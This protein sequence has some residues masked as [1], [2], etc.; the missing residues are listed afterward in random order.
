MHW[1]VEKLEDRIRMLEPYRYR[2]AIPLACGWQEDA[3]GEVGAYPPDLSR[4]A[5]AERGARWTGRDRYIWLKAQAEVPAHWQSRRAIGVFDFG[6][7][8]GGGNSGFESLLFIDGQPYQGVDT[9]HREVMLPDDAAGRTLPLV[10]RLWSGLGGYDSG[11]VLEHTLRRADLCWLDEA[12]DDL[13]YTGRAMLD[14]VKLL[15]DGRAERHEL[16]AALDEAFLLLDWSR[17]G[18][19][20]FYAS[21][22]RAQQVLQER[23]TCLPKQH[24]VTVQCIGHTHIDVA[25]LWRLKHT[26]E[27]AARSFSTVLRLMEQYPD[28]VFLQTQPQ[29][30][31]YIKTD[32]PQ[33]YEAIRERVAE[34]RWE[35]G[36]AMWLEADCNLTSGESLVRQLLYGIRFFQQEFGVTCRYLWLPDVFGYSWALPQILRQ[37]GIRAFMTT[38]ISWNQYNRM[39]HDTFRWR[40]IDG[41]EI[42]THFI[43]TPDPG[44]AEGSFFYTYNG[45]VTAE[46]VQGIWDGY[47]DKSVNRKLLL[48]YGYGD[49]GGGVNRDMLEMRRRLSQLPGLPQVTTGRADAFFE[50]LQETVDQT[51]Q[52][53]HTW[54]GELYLELHRGTYTS[55]AYNKRM[56]RKLELLYKET[57]WLA[58]RQAL[59]AGWRSY[60]QAAL[61]AGWKIIL[62]NQFHDIIPGSSI[63]EVYEDSREEYAEAELIAR[64]VWEQADGAL[65]R[66]G[67]GA[68]S[69]CGDDAEAES[70][71]AAGANHGA[72]G[73]PAPER[74]SVADA[75]A[76]SSRAADANHRAAGA[77]APGSRSYTV[78][79]SSSWER[80]ELVAI[81]GAA[82]LGEGRWYGA[83]GEKLEAQRSEAENS[84]LVR[85]PSVPSLGHAVIA[86]TPDAAP[87]KEAA[88]APGGPEIPFTAEP[89][90][91][92]SP[93]YV[94]EW[95]AAGH[96]VR[97]YD[98]QE[99]REVLA[100]GMQGN[101]LQVFEDKPKS[102]HEAWDIDL[103]YQEKQRTI[104]ELQE[105]RI[106]ELGELYAT[107][108]FRW[109]YMD[110]S[111][112]Q[113]MVLYARSRRIDFDTAVDWHEQRQLLKAAFPVDIRATEAT[114]DI[115]FGNVKRPTHWNT[116]WDYARFESVGHQWADL[117]ERSYGVSLLND[118]KYGY[119]IKDNR[120]RLTLI[121]SAA[122][123]D[124]TADQGEH[125]FTYAL[126]PHAGDWLQGGTVQAAYALN[127]PLSV[128]AGAAASAPASLFAISGGA[129]VMVDSVKKAEDQDKVVLRLH[130]YGGNRGTITITSEYDIVSWQAC[131]L[132]EEPEGEP[133]T[134]P[135]LS[136]TIKPY[137]LKTFLVAFHSSL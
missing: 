46:T 56:N 48:A 28:Y 102:R 129:H 57:E 2:D 8:G 69:R 53:V 119:D 85:V 32:Y 77:P 86:F 94:I 87:S 37:S 83:S 17:P 109:T 54:D 79:N 137:E 1:T 128:S 74:R 60:P 45:A 70:S 6:L 14:T 123:P 67:E 97:I 112:K 126:Y 51:G 25:W 62:R 27:K 38:K 55:Q 118:C 130:E 64:Q 103:F 49:G 31:E 124:P 23:L 113:K 110:S 63:R 10:F 84:W 52:Y 9:N 90:R 12:A 68:V 91:I 115:Q 101:V 100:P 24:A 114:Y 107:V 122:V 120:L 76:E 29:L 42:L 66:A 59:A 93:Y 99:N 36:G 58:V 61:Y 117:S 41:T 116:S 105:V 22:V 47:R 30:Y 88:S 133:V 98:K 40:G 111:V 106:T 131:S 44:G 125:R 72:A 16:L 92:E 96:L 43:T 81:S 4:A 20:A 7:T 121:K 82:Q 135:E 35:A 26:R 33:I 78:W 3:E 13:Y 95:N 134:G 34:G 108:E 39:P 65:T 136:C 75:E 89:G 71:R 80:T 19:E 132:L 50:E 104:E 73:A 11:A 18:S 15:G 5:A 21:V 127:H